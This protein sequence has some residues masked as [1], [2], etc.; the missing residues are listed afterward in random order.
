MD[1]KNLRFIWRNYMAE[2]QTTD[3]IDIKNNSFEAKRAHRWLFSVAG[4]KW[5]WAR[6]ASRPTFTVEPITIDYLNGKRYEA[7]K[8][9]W[10]PISVS[11]YDPIAPSASQK[12]MEWARLCYET[13]SGRSGYST[14]YK[15]EVTLEMLDPVGVIVESWAIK[16]AWITNASFGD[17]DYSSAELVQATIELRMDN[18]VLEY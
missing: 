7:G 12:I 9:E 15:R 6:T 10:S 4:E 3:V 1:Y 5:Y 14:F 18:C 11:L 16:G 2:I 17:L 13:L 8:M